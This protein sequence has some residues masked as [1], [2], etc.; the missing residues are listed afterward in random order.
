MT[1]CP[2]RAQRLRQGHGSGGAL[3]A[4]P[5]LALTPL[6]HPPP[7]GPR[8]QSA[9]TSPLRRASPDEPRGACPARDG[10]AGLA[11]RTLSPELS[12]R[13]RA[14][15]TLAPARAQEPPHAAP[16]AGCRAGGPGAGRESDAEA[17]RES[18]AEAGRASDAEAG[19]PPPAGGSAPGRG[20]AGAAPAA[21]ASLEEL[22]G[23]LEGAGPDTP[24]SVS[25][26]SSSVGAAVPCA[27]T[28]PADAAG[29]NGWA[30]F[31]DALCYD[32]PAARD[33]AP[34]LG[35]PLE[36]RRPQEPGGAQLQGDLGPAQQPGPCSEPVALSPAV[37]PMAGICVGALPVEPAA[38]QPQGFGSQSLRP[39]QRA[40]PGWLPSMGS[41]PLHAAQLRTPAWVP[42]N[43]PFRSQGATGGG[44]AE[45]QLPSSASLGRERQ[46][47]PLDLVAGE[48]GHLAGKQSAPSSR[49]GSSS[50]AHTQDAAAGVCF[51]NPPVEVFSRAGAR[52]VAPGNSAWSEAAAALQ[53]KSAPDPGGPPQLLGGHLGSG[54]APSEALWADWAAAGQDSA[55]AS[56]DLGL[57][58]RVPARRASRRGSS[59]AGD[60]PQL[61][62]VLAAGGVERGAGAGAASNSEQNPQGFAV[63][64][65]APAASLGGRQQVSLLDM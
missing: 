6:P 10:R 36:V 30:R 32:L 13:A 40:A 43:A 45:L 24:P 20:A 17:G 2:A 28:A 3:A 9:R 12:Q 47:F 27:L 19:V 18:D 42:D 35:H 15:G 59:A 55:A 8:S 33:A 34:Q 23:A 44:A 53:R 57:G 62:V 21:L 11:P 50:G 16:H 52:V 39:A 54:A 63:P 37:D 51:A 64:A 38:A 14:P 46:L 7:P 49:R 26:T 58:C 65:S 29:L 60:G 41:D 1:L 4:L 5:A 56:L 22:L 61:P 25:R 48:N 31:G